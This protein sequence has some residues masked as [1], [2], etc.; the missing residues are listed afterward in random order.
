MET[1]MAHI[2]MLTLRRKLG[3]LSDDVTN[4]RDIGYKWRSE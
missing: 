3:L 4:R 1:L 2:L